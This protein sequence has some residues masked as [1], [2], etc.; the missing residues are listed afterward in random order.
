MAGNSPPNTQIE[1]IT[2][3]IEDLGLIRPRWLGKSNATDRWM[4]ARALLAQYFQAVQEILSS[5]KILAPSIK[6]NTQAIKELTKDML[7]LNRQ[8]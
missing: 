7:T 2:V 3:R 1:R 4:P 8:P 6:A 5:S